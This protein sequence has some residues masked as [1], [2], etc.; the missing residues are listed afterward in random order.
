MLPTVEA[1]EPQA[2]VQ[3]LKLGGADYAH[4]QRELRTAS[5]NHFAE[6]EA[7]G[8]SGEIR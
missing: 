4:G 1:V 6:S 7:N 8:G 5:R 3:K 2:I